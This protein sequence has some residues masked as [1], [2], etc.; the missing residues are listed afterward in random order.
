MKVLVSSYYDRE[1]IAPPIEHLKTQAD[2]VFC[3]EARRLTEEEL[4]THLQGIDVIIAADDPFT[5][6]VFEN[7]P[8]LKMVALDGVGVDNVDLKAATRFGVIVNNAPVNHESM[9]DLAFGLMLAAVRKITIGDRGMRG[10]RYGDRHDYLCR[11]DV[12]GSTLGLLGF[13]R[14]AR[15]VARRALGFNMTILAHDPYV[16]PAAAAALNVRMVSLDELLAS[17]DIVSLHVVLTD[18]TRGMIAASAFA[19]MKDG[20]FI[21]NTSRGAVIDE[22]ALIAALQ[23]G[24]AAGAGLDV[25]C[26][27]PPAPDDPL[28]QFDN[29]VFTAHVGSDT[30]DTFRRTFEL[31]V[32]DISLFMAGQQPGHVVNQDVFDH[33]RFARGES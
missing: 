20:V 8:Q 21:V 6:H 26:H 9:A 23:S 4:V 24:K 18:Q 13:G 29:V 5:R 14:V 17:S 15:A 1:A 7:C 28:F 16:E 12:N 3:S 25:M 22:P 31:V 2:V 19:K 30:F 11:R 32:H 33:P 27:E 10:G